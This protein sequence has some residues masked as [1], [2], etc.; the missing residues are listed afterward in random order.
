MTNQLRTN[1]RQYRA[2]GS[3]FGMWA[4]I[5]RAQERADLEAIKR[6]KIEMDIYLAHQRAAM[7]QNQLVLT[8]LKIIEQKHRL[9]SLGLLGRQFRVTGPELEGGHND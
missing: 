3:L 1:A 5:L 7:I 4:R 2:I 8:D 6:H 9:E